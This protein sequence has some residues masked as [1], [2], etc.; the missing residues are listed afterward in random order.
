MKKST[1]DQLIHRQLQLVLCYAPAGLG[2]LRIMDAL[3]HGL[4]DTVNPVVLGSQDE[5]IRI[6]HRLTSTH[7]IG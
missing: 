3:Y 6:I 5:S 2:H 1:V 4:P 7:P